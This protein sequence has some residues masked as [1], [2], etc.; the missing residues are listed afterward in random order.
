[1]H[2]LQKR[3][4]TTAFTNKRNT[5]PGSADTQHVLRYSQ[6]WISALLS[7]LRSWTP[8]LAEGFQLYFTSKTLASPLIIWVGQELSL[9]HP[10]AG[11]ARALA[12]K[13]ITS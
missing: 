12:L 13:F 10:G 1:M 3:Y 5:G 4:T 6:V 7:D 9:V 8:P 2:C 11:P